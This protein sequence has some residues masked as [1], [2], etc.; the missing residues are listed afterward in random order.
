MAKKRQAA[1]EEG[2]SW[3]D[4]YGDMITLILTFF[5]LLYSMSSMDQTKW[6]YIAEAFSRG[7]IAQKTEIRVVG[8]ENP[9]N[10]PTAVYMAEVPEVEDDAQIV[11][12]EDFYLYLQQV[13]ANSNLENSV[14]LEMSALGVYMKF[15]DNVFFKGDSDVLVDDGKYIIDV[16]CDGIRQI[17]DRI[18]SIQVSGFTAGSSTSTVDEWELSSG[19]ASSV[20]QYMIGLDACEPSKFSGRAYGKYRPIEDNDTE[21]GRRQNRRVEIIFIREDADFTDP[22][23]VKELMELEFGKSFV[24][25]TDA[26]GVQ[27]ETSEDEEDA[28]ADIFDNSDPDRIYVSKEDIVTK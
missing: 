3:M 19:R 27:D 8:A 24:K 1:E 9:E 7:N 16:I 5:V 11:D 13:I 22:E 15:R 14:G 10:D 20:I 25:Y 21:E 12:F 6:Q 26:E 17:S 18:R 2:G 28:L 4:T 23:V